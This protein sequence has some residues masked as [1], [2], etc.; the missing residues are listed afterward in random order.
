MAG[1]NHVGRKPVDIVY[2]GRRASG[3][4]DLDTRHACCVNVSLSTQY[5]LLSFVLQG[6]SCATQFG[7]YSL[8]KVLF[9]PTR[10]HRVPLAINGNIGAHAGR[11]PIRPMTN[12]HFYHT[13]LHMHSIPTLLTNV[14]LTVD[15]AVA[16]FPCPSY[17]GQ[18]RVLSQAHLTVDSR[19]F[20]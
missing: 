11:R 17:A 12:Y 8:K 14:P 10:R 1:N 6:V 5:T 20:L 18:S 4:S 16:P 7:A 3:S 19:L 9:R 13:N 2:L 15:K